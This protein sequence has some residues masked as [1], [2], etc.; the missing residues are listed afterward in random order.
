LVAKSLRI[1]A[2]APYPPRIAA[3]H[4][5][6]K[7]LGEF[8]LHTTA[9]HEVGLAHLFHPG[10]P[11]V[12]ETLRARVAFVE[13]VPRPGEPHGATHLRRALARRLR[14]LGGTPLAVSELASEEFERVV[15]RIIRTWQPDLIRL[16]PAVSASFVRDSQVP[17]VLVDHDPLLAT[18]DDP[19]GLMRRAEAALD[20]RV[21]RRYDRGARAGADAVVAF[22]ER[23]TRAIAAAGGAQRLVQ[24]PLA[25]EP[26]PELDPSGK[27]EG[28][29][30]FVGN[31]NH[32]ANRQAVRHAVD[33]I[34]PDV[35]RARAEATLTVVGQLPADGSFHVEGAGI[36]LTGLVDEVVPYLDEAAVFVAPIRT[37]GGM[38]VKVLEA[39][40][41][42]KAVVAYPEALDG[43][44]VA[45]ERQVLVATSPQDFAALVVRLLADRNARTELGR[46]AREWALANVSWEAVLDAYDELYG[47]VLAGP[48]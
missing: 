46:A 21:G 25:I 11:A 44:A 19:R 24:I 43:L 22:T 34:F 10:E 41:A 29:L 26:L 48:S 7:A 15:Q 36:R 12:D 40:S 13:S 30:L 47:V 4:G 9:R 28:S 37:G 20:H 8:L 3:T 33:D 23:D 39:L 27:R 2:V 38:R 31:L 35:R 17:K 6:A 42:G 1:L 45:H 18:A 16:E 5:G 32:P 14:L